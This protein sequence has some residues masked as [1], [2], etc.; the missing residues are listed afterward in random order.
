MP[1]FELE[2]LMNRYRWR[3]KLAWYEDI[4]VRLDG[5]RGGRMDVW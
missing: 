4:S 3:F 2:V 1:D 5:N